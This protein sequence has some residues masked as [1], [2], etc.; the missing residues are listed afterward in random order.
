MIDVM[1][2]VNVPSLGIEKG[3]V[4]GRTFGIQTVDVQDKDGRIHKEIHFADVT[5][6]DP[7]KRKHAA[8]NHDLSDRQVDDDD[9]AEA[10]G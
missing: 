9:A 7:V 6:T 10:E 8:R 2:L 3:I 4:V 5:H 1:D